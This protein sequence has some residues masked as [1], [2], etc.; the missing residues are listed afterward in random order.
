MD[1][2]PYRCDVKADFDRYHYRITTGQRK[3]WDGEPDL[4]KEGW[5]EWADWERFDFTEER[6]WRKPLTGEELAVAQR[7]KADRERTTAV[8]KAERKVIEAAKYLVHGW[9]FT[10]DMGHEITV[11]AWSDYSK[12]LLEERIRELLAAEKGE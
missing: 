3:C 11:P 1:E 7:A 9:S 6:Y 12:V 2:L 10:D 5:E 8:L 4:S